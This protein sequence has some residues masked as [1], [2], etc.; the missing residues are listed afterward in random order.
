VSSERAPSEIPLTAPPPGAVSDAGRA[1]SPSRSLYERLG[2]LVC[3][4]IPYLAV[5]A[6]LHATLGSSRGYSWMRPVQIL[7]Q[8]ARGAFFPTS[9]AVVFFLGEASRL[10]REDFVRFA[11][12][13]GTKI[14]L[15][16]HRR[17]IAAGAMGALVLMCL[18]A[19]NRD[20]ELVDYFALA[21]LGAVVGLRRQA[22]AVYLRSLGQLL[23][24]LILFTAVSYSFTVFKAFL[25]YFREP[26]DAGIVLLEHFI[27]RVYPHRI[28]AAWASEHLWVVPLSDWVYYLLFNHMAL[29]SLFLVGAR[30]PEERVQFIASLALCYLIGGVASYAWPGLGPGYYE[31][32]VYDYLDRLPLAT[33]AFRRILL[34]NTTALANGD[35]GQIQTYEYIA[36]MPSL[37]M[38][39]EFV[40]LY[41]ARRSRPFFVASIAFTS[42]T[43]L[44]IVILGWHYPIDAVAGAALAASAIWVAHRQR[45]QLFPAGIATTAVPSTDAPHARGR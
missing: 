8:V 18:G 26:H 30:R 25:F 11:R 1:R 22:K 5:A 29:V 44:A 15:A 38:A 16:P 19:V 10:R 32:E 34:R 37:H 17:R 4:G 7:Y 35:P 24:V 21:L 13:L 3:V 43:L 14:D 39:H 33:N 6:V 28:I 31:P 9:A 2:L 41:F 27:F 12:S 36:C 40:M 42:F 45:G 20:Y 23:F